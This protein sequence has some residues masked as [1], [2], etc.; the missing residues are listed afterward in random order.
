[1]INPVPLLRI[2][3]TYWLSL[4]VLLA[5]AS[6][7]T[8][9]AEVIYTS[10]VPPGGNP[11]LY[12]NFRDDWFQTVQRKFDR[13][14][15]K[16]FDIVFDGD[17]ITNRWETTGKEFWSKYFEGHAADFGIEGDRIE[18]VRWR[19]I[20]GQLDGINPKLIVLM[21]GTN[22]SG[23]DSAEQIAEG[24]KA[25]VSDYRN[26]CPQA[27]IVLMGVFPRGANS[28]DPIRQKVAAINRLI[29]SSADGLHVSYLDIGP[30][31]VNSDGSISKEMMPDFLH[32]T[33]I[34]Y[35]VWTKALLP[36]VEKYAPAPK[37]GT[38]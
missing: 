9:S 30:D 18:N 34:G 25:L 31:L 8:F 38:R 3:R 20:K 35:E 17:S 7:P 12:A 11:A 14:S 36:F 24:I 28:G 15:M 6:Q 13:F 5:L 32:P 29:A 22:N 33:A 19:L 16:P 21:I 1:M 23:R 27:H 26:R 10:P 4:T 2:L 37:N